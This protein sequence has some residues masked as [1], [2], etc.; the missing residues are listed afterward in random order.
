MQGE[1]GL[2]TVSVS[3]APTLISTQHP[4]HF[5]GVVC[6]CT[7]SLAYTAA[8]ELCSWWGA[9]SEGYDCRRGCGWEGKLGHGDNAC[10]A[11]PTPVQPLLHTN[12]VSASCGRW[13]KSSRRAG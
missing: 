1:L 10:K 7:H 2:G 11:I 6:G 4:M 5:L 9:F 8:G 12:V 3:L 13:L